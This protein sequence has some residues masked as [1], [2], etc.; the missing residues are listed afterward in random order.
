M[1]RGG[2]RRYLALSLVFAA[3]FVASFFLGRYAVSAESLLRILTAPFNAA[4]LEG[5]TTEFAVIFRIRLPR[6][7]AAA[8]IGAALATAGA[9]YQGM[10][11]NPMVSPD[12]LGAST[13][14]GF[15]AA[16]GI[17]LSFGY[18]GI[19]A[20]AF[21]FGL[22]AVSLSYAVSRVSRLDETLSLVLA[23]VMISS[24]FS[25][26]TSFVKLVADTED[27]LPAITYWLMGS[28]ASVKLEDLPFAAIPIALGY[29]P[30]FLLRWRINILTAEE[31]EARSLGLDVGRMRFIVIVCATL[32]TAASV[33][34]SGMIGWVGLVIPHFCRLIFGYDYHRLIPV[35][36]LMGASFLTVVDNVAR[37]AATSEIPLGILTSFVGAPLFVY[38]ILTGGVARAR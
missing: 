11:R 30:L 12:I 24:L 1:N 10:F 27:Q 37:I 17:L 35:S 21:L 26:C 5:V 29:V 16:L 28:L 25:A 15:G 36:A 13:G 20:S 3:V 2:G 19:T 32:M 7:I 8:L 22:G 14:A 4:G 9:A 33:A 18:F 31:D 34:I 38:L 23:G 6:V